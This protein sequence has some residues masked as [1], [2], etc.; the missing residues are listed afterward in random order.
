MSDLV[1]WLRLKS[2]WDGDGYSPSS[3]CNEAADRI[4]ELEAALAKARENALLEAANLQRYY[5][6]YGDMLDL[7]DGEYVKHSDILALIERK[8]E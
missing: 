2:E 5:N 1:T 4:E 3:L 7:D 8:P 6:E